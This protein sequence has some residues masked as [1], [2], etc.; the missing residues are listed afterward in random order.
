[1]EE[2]QELSSDL[3]GKEEKRS[4]VGN[5]R[6]PDRKGDGGK[7]DDLH[8]GRRRE[9]VRTLKVGRRKGKQVTKADKG[10]LTILEAFNAFS[11]SV[12]EKNGKEA[13]GGIRLPL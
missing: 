6:P 7:R 12:G 9:K 3:I 13:L 5:G 10:P 4:Q 1:V 8:M 2:S 11:Y